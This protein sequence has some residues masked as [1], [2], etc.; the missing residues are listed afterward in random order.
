MKEAQDLV[1]Y[2]VTC[3]T[4]NTDDMTLIT[5]LDENGV[6]LKLTIKEAQAGRVIGKRGETVQAIRGLLRA[7]GT[8]NNAKYSL[9]VEID[10]NE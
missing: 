10:E 6:L 5:S 8:K 2:I 4:G 3:I 9:L 1:E 7:L